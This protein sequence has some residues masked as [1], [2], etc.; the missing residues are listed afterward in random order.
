MR[1]TVAISHR[2]GLFDPVAECAERDDAESTTAYDPLSAGER[3]WIDDLRRQ[4]LANPEGVPDA[5]CDR[6]D[7]LAEAGLR[8][9]VFGGTASAPAPPETRDRRHDPHRR[10]R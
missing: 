9:S 2:G 1:I 4:R 8:I 6:F 10:P 3:A 5:D 7:R